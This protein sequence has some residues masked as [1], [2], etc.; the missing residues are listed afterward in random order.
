MPPTIRPMTVE[1]FPQ[2]YKLGLMC[3]KVLD[4][5]YNYWTMAEVTD[6]LENH[7]DLCYVAD[8]DGKI[9]GFALG[10]K[11]FLVL[12]DTGHLEWVAVHPEYRRQGVS[13]QLMNAVLDV[14][15]ALGKKEVVTDISTENPASRG[16]ARKLGYTEGISMTFFVKKLNDAPSTE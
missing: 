13:L 11:E 12:K 6:H 4:K 16:M 9:V 7:G 1:D 8:D 5:P 3:Y 2:V 14:Y 15:R 10:A